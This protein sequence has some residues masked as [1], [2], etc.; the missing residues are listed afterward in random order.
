MSYRDFGPQ[1]YE[2]DGKPTASSP[3]TTVLSAPTIE[4]ENNVTICH[5]L[6]DPALTTVGPWCAIEYF[7]SSDADGP[8]LWTRGTQ[9]ATGSQELSWLH[10][11]ELMHADGLGN[12]QELRAGR[13][14][15]VTNGS[16][17]KH[18]VY[19]RD[20]YVGPIG[21]VRLRI[22]LPS[23]Q[24]DIAPSWEYHSMLPVTTGQKFR[25]TILAGELD[26]MR[27]PA[28]TYSPLFGADVA[29]SP[30]ANL[31]LP[32]QR[33]F[34]YAALVTN[35][36]ASIERVAVN[37]D[38]LIHLGMGRNELEISSESDSR[39]LLFGGEPLPQKHVMWRGFIAEDRNEVERF[40][41]KWT[42]KR[43]DDVPETEDRFPEPTRRSR[44]RA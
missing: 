24:R 40:R 11:G 12:Q 26:G 43:F 2:Y 22:A 36:T 33:D 38:S 6:P 14:G 4:T 44:L 23:S 16:G 30:R 21:G 5:A 18:G 10:C 35:G 20:N 19:T 3:V 29:L 28:T 1:L 9:P 25:A 39:L 42:T 8:S 7:R 27:S 17:L 32:L 13:L 34:E 37:A 15:V 31:R 41:I